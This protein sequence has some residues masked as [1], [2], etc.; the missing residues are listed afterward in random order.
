MTASKPPKRGRGRAATP[1]EVARVRR[2]VAR[3]A[4]LDEDVVAMLTDLDAVAETQ[5][6]EMLGEDRGWVRR[7]KR[8]A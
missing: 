1:D 3:R 6:A 7:H 8:P 4:A 5:L 2:L